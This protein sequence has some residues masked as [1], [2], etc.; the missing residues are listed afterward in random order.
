M[1]SPM[2]NALHACARLSHTVLNQSSH[3]ILLIGRDLVSLKDDFKP[4]R[5]SEVVFMANAN[6]EAWWDEDHYSL[7]IACLKD[8]D[9]K[10]AKHIHNHTRRCIIF[11]VGS[12]LDN[13]SIFMLARDLKFDL[14]FDWKVVSVENGKEYAA[15][16]M[17]SI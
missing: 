13:H 14:K 11:A 3:A 1:Q 16:L 5:H 8:L 7:T 9:L 15:I 4:Y 6:D 10:S 17:E 2:N 12:Q